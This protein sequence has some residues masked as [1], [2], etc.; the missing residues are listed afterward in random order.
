MLAL[1]AVGLSL[2]F[3]TTGIS[4]FAH[5]EMVTFGAVAA[6]FLVGPATVALPWWLGYPTVVVLGA[7]FGLVMDMVLWR[8]LRRRR[9]GVVQLLIVSIDRKSTRLNSSP[10]CATRMP[11]SA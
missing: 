3:G 9:V 7:V 10:K 6:L 8:P 2:V 4:N 5:G 1:A 11:S